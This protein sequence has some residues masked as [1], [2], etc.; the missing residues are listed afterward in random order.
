M[1]I[2]V[3]HLSGLNVKLAQRDPVPIYPR[4][5][6]SDLPACGLNR[7]ASRLIRAG[8]RER[9]ARIA[10]M[11]SFIVRGGYSPCLLGR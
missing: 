4:E 6:T 2:C 3:F 1:I 10:D 9:I 11:A 5:I 7:M 8:V